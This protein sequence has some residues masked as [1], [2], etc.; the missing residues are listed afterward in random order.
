MSDKYLYVWER[1]EHHNYVHK[2]FQMKVILDNA[3]YHGLQRRVSST[4]EGK[5][6]SSVRR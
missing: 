6:I 4:R 1:L 3:C 5:E 2:E